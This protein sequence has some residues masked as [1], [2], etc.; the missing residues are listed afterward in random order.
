[1]YMSTYF[2]F[3][4][5]ANKAHQAK[6]YVVSTTLTKVKGVSYTNLSTVDPSN[7]AVEDISPY[8]R[9][10]D[11]ADYVIPPQMQNSFFV[12]TNMVITEDQTQGEC[13]E[14]PSISSAICV[15]DSDCSIPS[16]VRGHGPRT[17]RCIDHPGT[18]L[19]YPGNKTCEVRTW[20]PVEKDQLPR[21][22]RAVL[23]EAANFTVLIKNA[24]TFPKF[25]FRKRNILQTDNSTFLEKCLY[26]EEDESYSM[27]PIFRLGDIVEYAGHDFEKIAYTG[28][29][30]GIVIDWTCNLDISHDKCKPKYKF[31]RIY[32]EDAKIAP[33]FNFRFS[34]KYRNNGI[35]YRTLTK[36][37]GILFEIV[38][39]GEAGKC[40]ATKILLLIGATIGAISIVSG[41]FT[42][43]MRA[44][45][46]Q[47]DN[48][49]NEIF[50]DKKWSCRN[51]FDEIRQSFKEGF[52]KLK[53]C[54]CFSGEA[55]GDDSN[56]GE[57]SGDDNKRKGQ[58]FA[59][60]AYEHA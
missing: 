4:L 54:K 14:D 36:A 40:S 50:E 13:A 38:V 46:K 27:C 35:T 52:V 25:D 12:M 58:E 30:I 18:T 3:A 42:C 6:D 20:C 1:M 44:S 29:S 15:N 53:S 26:N 23:Y 43:I 5:I 39:E 7:I 51:R 2:R 48:A 45:N 60:A 55:R 9:V 22:D 17:G 24:I 34:Y 19:E 21:T 11:E 32:R 33:G 47:F 56:S 8:N 37:Y 59:N 31:L 28:G 57:A 41:I 16:P 10:W 49:S